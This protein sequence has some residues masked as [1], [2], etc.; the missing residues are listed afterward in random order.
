MIYIYITEN[1]HGEAKNPP[2]FGKKEKNLKQTSILRNWRKHPYMWFK[3]TF[4]FFLGEFGEL[5]M[6]RCFAEFCFGMDFW[7]DAG[8]LREI[9]QTVKIL[10][11]LSYFVGHQQPALEDLWFVSKNP[12]LSLTWTCTPNIWGFER[13]VGRASRRPQSDQRLVVAG[14]VAERLSDLLQSERASLG[15]WKAGTSGRY[16]AALTSTTKLDRTC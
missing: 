10:V 13:C 3:W 8:S 9:F 5:W 15:S 1:Y 2:F 14:T 16:N 4:C 6:F 11:P 12:F 7:L